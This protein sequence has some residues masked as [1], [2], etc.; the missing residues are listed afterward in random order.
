MRAVAQR[1]TWLPGAQSATVLTKEDATYSPNPAAL[2][3]IILYPQHPRLATA[4][5]QPP[6]A[7]PAAV[8]APEH[9]T[10]AWT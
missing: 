6:Y 4:T 10:R 8:I 5:R 7:T 1:P 2:V 3:I 9:D